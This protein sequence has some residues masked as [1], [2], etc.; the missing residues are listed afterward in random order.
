[1]SETDTEVIVHA[2]EQYG[3]SC[4]NHFRGIFAFAIYDRN[5]KQLFLAR[6][7]IGVKPLY[8]H[9]DGK[10]II[11]ASEIKSILLH[12]SVRRN[13]CKRVV[14]D[15]LSFRYIPGEDTLFDNI[16]KLC[17]GSYLTF[18]RGKIEIK[19]YY[20]LAV[21]DKGDLGEAHYVK[22]LRKM[23]LDSVDE[24]MM[25]DVPLGVYLSGGLDSTAVLAF[26][27]K[28]RSLSDQE[29]QI[30]TFSIGFGDYEDHSGEMNHA[31]NAAEHFGTDHH[32]I[33]I[34]PESVKTIPKVIWHLDEPISD[35]TTI[36]TM[37]LSEF[38][39]K[40]VV[41]NQS[42][43]GG[44]EIFGGY[45]QYGMINKL[46]RYVRP[47]PAML[48]RGLF[49]PII[50]TIPI[51]MLDKVFNYPSSL[52]VEGRERLVEFVRDAESRTKSYLN[53]ISVFSEAEKKCVLTE[54]WKQS[55]AKDDISK[56]VGNR[57]FT[58]NRTCFLDQVFLRENNTWLPDYI[59]TR[60]DKMT[61]AHSIES[62]VPLL[63]I[64]LIE[65]SA[66]MPRH[67]KIDKLILKKAAA[68]MV[69]KEIIQRKKHPFYI[70]IDSWFGKGIRD[71]AKQAIGS[72]KI[73]DTLFRKSYTKKLLNR[74]GSSNLVHSRQLWSLLTLSIWHK[75]YIENDV[76]KPILDLDRLL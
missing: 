10:D 30:K 37:L 61:M 42:G 35:A 63:D 70:P 41:V 65:F 73:V 21:Q 47:I 51:A 27:K 5:K 34:G 7:H 57:W 40:W 49:P 66:T 28:A 18:H 52:G 15:Y 53:L 16:K 1:M 72:S 62:R 14:N 11:F 3:S 31:R 43:E 12:P 4:V 39:R 64:R 13:I 20:T 23:L 59:L 48:R 26:M 71:I 33:F 22:K 2:Y 55:I 32:E 56:K 24:Q 75:L 6:D 76:K 46:E 67:Y 9:Y 58:D 54:R 25:S 74:R 44:D 17:P 69:P 29:E 36:P 50:R 45:V 8:Y 68:G 38:A 60:L 19:K